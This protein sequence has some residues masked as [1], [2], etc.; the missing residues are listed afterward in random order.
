MK[1]TRRTLLRT[2]STLTAGLAGATTVSAT[3]SPPQWDPDT[4][5]TD[6]DR[7]VYDGTVWEAQ[8]W[9]R[10]NE[11]G[12]REWGPWDRVEDA[13]DDPDPEP[14]EGPTASIAVSETPV[15]PTES[16]VFDA[17]DSAG[18]ID[19]YEWDFGDG[20]EAAGDVVEHAYD[21]AGEYGV[22][23]VVTDTDGRTDAASTTVSV[24]ERDADPD[25]ITADTTIAEFYG[26]YDERYVPE[27]FDNWMPD[28]AS[29]YGA[30]TDAIRNNVDDGSLEFGSLGTQALPWVQQFDDAGLPRH[31]SSQLLPW[32]SVLPE[33]TETPTF[34]GSGRSVA[35][36]Q[37]A[38]PT[39][40]TNDPSTFVQP[41]WPTDAIGEADEEVAERDAVHNQPQHR[42]DW[43]SHF[44]LPD[45]ILYNHDNQLLDTI[46]NDVHP[47]TGDP[48]GG[49]GFTANAPME[50]TA[51]VHADGWSGHQVLVFEN[52][53][54]VPY[55]LDGAVIWWVGPSKYGKTMS[56]G[57]YN[58]EQ[59]PEPGVGHPQRDI[60]EVVLDDEHMPEQYEGEDVDLS[61]FAVRL[62]FHDSPYMF[63]TAYPGQYWSLEIRTGDNLAGRHQGDDERQRLVDTMVETCHVELRQD[64]DIERNTELVET[65]ELTN[66]V[67]N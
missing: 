16:V 62:A 55:H 21:D 7:V 42:D 41:Q 15:P 8:W 13:P 39:A 25:D 45:E 35:W 63:R 31:A 47:V 3:E 58:N 12:S 4:V 24:E 10:G 49:D 67:A 20:T 17:T 48:L 23:L 32:L 50:V 1:P 40:A 28:A 34:Q 64:L 33:E 37:T 29:D 36:D 51:E 65:I 54:S 11:P 66:R 44:S 43:D 61:A 57:H 46:A 9:T 27:L 19:A 26:D 22:E 14:P 59:R 5:Y 2:V 60:I 18:E 53:S 56:A 30:D 38:G 52:T 6:G